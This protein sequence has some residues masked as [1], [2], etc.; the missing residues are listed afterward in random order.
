MANQRGESAQWQHCCAIE[1]VPSLSALFHLDKPDD[2]INAADKSEDGSFQD[3]LKNVHLS[4]STDG[5]L[6]AIANACQTVFMTA[7]VNTDD[8]GLRKYQLA[9]QGSLEGANGDTITAI[10]ALTVSPPNSRTAWHVVLV[11]FSDGHL[12]AYLPRGEF[13]MSH[14]LHRGAINMIHCQAGGVRTRNLRSYGEEVLLVY[15]NTVVALDGDSLLKCLRTCV[16]RGRGAEQEQQLSYKKYAFNDAGKIQGFASVGSY[17]RTSLSLMREASFRNEG[18]SL[19]QG[20]MMTSYMASSTC[21]PFITYDAY[22]KMITP[23]LSL[24]ASVVAQRLRS[25]VVSQLSWAG[26]LLGVGEGAAEK[27]GRDPSTPVPPW[28]RIHDSGRKGRSVVI[29]PCGRW[30]ATT[31]SLGRVLQ[32]DTTSMLVLRMWKGYRDAQCGWIAETEDLPDDV[33]PD[34]A[35]PGRIAIFLLIYAPRRGIVELWPSDGG[36]R[37]GAYNVGKQCC[38]LYNPLSVLG[39][40]CRGSIYPVLYQCALLHPSGN[41]WSLRVPFTNALSRDEQQALAD[42][43]VVNRLAGADSESPSADELP[44]MLLSVGNPMQAQRALALAIQRSYPA[45]ALLKSCQVLLDKWQGPEENTL[46]QSC[47]HNICLLSLYNKCNPNNGPGIVQETPLHQV[48]AKFSVVHELPQYDLESLVAIAEST[49]D[50]ILSL[51]DGTPLKHVEPLDVGQFVLAFKAG[52]GSD[53]AMLQLNPKLS[54]DD[55]DSTGLALCQATLSGDLDCGDFFAICLEAGLP[56]AT[57]SDLVLRAFIA[58][59]VFSMAGALLLN[60]HAILELL[61]AESS[62]DLWPAAHSVLLQAERTGAAWLAAVALEHLVKSK[63]AAVKESGSAGDEQVSDDS[64]E[65]QTINASFEEWRQMQIR[66]RDLTFFSSVTKLAVSVDSVLATD[67][68]LITLQTAKWIVCNKHMPRDVCP[69]QARPSAMD[70]DEEGT[71][72]PNPDPVADDGEAEEKARLLPLTVLSLQAVFPASLHHDVLM[73]ECCHAAAL[74]WYED[75]ESAEWLDLSLQYSTDITSNSLK[76]AVSVLV[77]D[78]FLVKYVHTMLEVLNKVGLTVKDSVC[79]RHLGMTWLG[80]QRFLAQCYRYMYCL[81]EYSRPYRQRPPLP[82]FECDVNWDVHGWH[83]WPGAYVISRLRYQK[84][85]SHVLVKLQRDLLAI[86]HARMLLE[87][88]YKPSNLFPVKA[89]EALTLPLCDPSG[90]LYALPISDELELTRE[91]ALCQLCPFAVH[92]QGGIDQIEALLTLLHMKGDLVRQ[93][94]VLE[95][96]RLGDQR[97]TR[98]AVQLARPMK[99]TRELGV[100]LFDLASERLR[101]HF[102]E[103]FTE[104]QQIEFMA[105]VTPTLSAMLQVKLTLPKGRQVTDETRAGLTALRVMFR[106]VCS[107][108]SSSSRQ[109]SY[110]QQILE[111]LDHRCFA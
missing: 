19:V 45:N 41:I 92:S 29:S 26:S 66:L 7:S 42:Q 20:D 82:E 4:V 22:E 93:R 98:Q 59:P 77:W 88:R 21:P 103:L 44:T 48:L 39:Q 9:W 43:D 105:R 28:R 65:W 56:V 60:L 84:P 54:E 73:T 63:R 14:R 40:S 34:E 83:S 109:Y 95:L 18:M 57:I 81:E 71:P 2:N 64:D 5:F 85:P 62:D 6:L 12:R 102:T 11:G 75:K 68:T 47:L 91:K 52:F 10:L 8:D 79:R 51:Q 25:A 101:S 72:P 96:Y 61:D 90:D 16:T 24:V 110:S 78:T 97:S 111:A 67:C 23:S 33:D 50:L 3:W 53:G 46:C 37:I 69:L 30:V 87:G 76:Q 27:E 1:M 107:L 35:P 38:L 55:L 70:D 94:L 15:E 17:T 13:V 89:R 36:A 31:D 86:M 106:E 108:L 99:D 80:C 74:M 32:I 49:N 100:E 58:T 104:Q